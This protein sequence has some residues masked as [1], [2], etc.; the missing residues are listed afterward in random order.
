M[1]VLVDAR[2]LSWTFRQKAFA[3]PHLMAPRGKPTMQAAFAPAKAT[4]ANEGVESLGFIPADPADLRLTVAGAVCD[5][6]GKIDIEAYE[7]I[8]KCWE[9]EP[10]PQNHPN[11]HHPGVRP[12]EQV[13]KGMR[14]WDD[15]RAGCTGKDGAGWIAAKSSK[16]LGKKEKWFNIRTCG[17]WRLAFLLAKLQHQVWEQQNDALVA[18][19]AQAEGKN[20]TQATPAAKRARSAGSSNQET[21]PKS[22]K[23]SKATGGESQAE[24]LKPPQEGKSLLQRSQDA[25]GSKLSSV[26]D[27]I[28]AKVGKTG[29]A[30]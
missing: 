21:P 26:F 9:G 4:A 7:D 6:Q 15:V 23:V 12:G 19:A 29:D 30:A 20:D 18:K 1:S 27:R 2:R 17:S 24:L 22:Q 25:S 28:R 16:H 8:M 10:A 11:P 3:D 14:I 13:L 5:S